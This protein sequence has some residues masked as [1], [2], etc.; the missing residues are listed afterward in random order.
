LDVVAGGG[1]VAAEGVLVVDGFVADQVDFVVVVDFAAEV[2]LEPEQLGV[3]CCSAVVD[4]SVF[5]D[6]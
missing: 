4:Y 1:F 6:C 5:V 2:V 3:D